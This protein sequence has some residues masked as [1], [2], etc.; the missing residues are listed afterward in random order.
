MTYILLQGDCREIMPNLVPGA[1]LILTDPPFGISN[2]NNSSGASSDFSGYTSDKGEWD[3]EV[4]ATEWVP[5]ACRLLKPNG[6]FACF[7]TFGSLVPIFQELEKCSMKFQS[8]ITWHKTNPAPSI[9]RRMLT[10][11]NEIILLFSKGP[12]WYFDYAYGK[13]I[14]AGKQLHNH[15]DCAAVRKQAGVTRKPPELCKKLIQ[16]FCPP[17]GIVLDPFAGSG[18]I[19]EAAK[20][21][22]RSYI[23]IEKLSECYQWMVN[24]GL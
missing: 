17:D 11:A 16:L 4:A 21:T 6:L 24:K 18:A 14:N 23:A 8:H 7:G 1:D 3:I 22:G 2:Q 20:D 10:H 13:S 9:H 19:P 12:G 5:E 15:F